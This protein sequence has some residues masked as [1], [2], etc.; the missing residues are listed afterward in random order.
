MAKRKAGLHK[1]IASIFSGVP[2]SKNES[3]HSSA[4]NSAP[5][6]KNNLAPSPNQPT[7]YKVSPKPEPKPE[8]VPKPEKKFETAA[9]TAKKIAKTPTKTPEKELKEKVDDMVQKTKQ[10]D[11]GTAPTAEGLVEEAKSEVD[12]EAEIAQKVL[13]K[14]KRIITREEKQS[15]PKKILEGKP[16]DVDEV[17]K[18]M[19]KLQKKGTLR[20]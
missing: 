12:K 20:K 13:K 2:I 18:L 1:E 19:K 16:D 10:H 17:Q 4:N 8:P 11:D 3:Q 5:D 15:Q 6:Y 14:G 7:E 9:E